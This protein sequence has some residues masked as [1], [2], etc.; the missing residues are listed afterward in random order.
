MYNNESP[1]NYMNDKI[2][3]KI[4]SKEYL[5][6][7]NCGSNRKQVYDLSNI[8]K[9]I[10]D[11][12]GD[13]ISDKNLYIGEMTGMYWLWKNYEKI[14]N[15]EYIGTCHYRRFF[16]EKDITDYQN[17]DIIGIYNKSI[18]PVSMYQQYC[19]N[20]NHSREL[21]DYL[22]DSL[23]EQGSIIARNYFNNNL[24]IFKQCNMFI[25][26][27]EI[28][29]KYCEFIFR[30][31]DRAWNFIDPQNSLNN[32]IDEDKRVISFAIER[33]TSFWLDFITIQN[34]LQL[35]NLFNIEFYKTKPW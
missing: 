31:I 14:G 33:F 29:F 10:N 4:N 27:K 20:K 19:S 22:I 17:Y 8:K 28:F 21:F 25:M 24:S 23:G 7:I 2:I 18:F 16:I 1:F 12:T 5:V 13:N 11:N 30:M 3:E 35:K 15:P 32:L 6:P 9:L 34:R 26:K